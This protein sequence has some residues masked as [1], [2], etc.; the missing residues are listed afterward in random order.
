[1]IV[2]RIQ[3][4]DVVDLIFPPMCTDI[5][6]LVTQRSLHRYRSDMNCRKAACITLNGRM[7]CRSHASV[8]LMDY[9]IVKGE[10]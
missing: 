8:R 2:K 10:V 1:M 6:S 9:A 3:K 7:F 5:V 4:D